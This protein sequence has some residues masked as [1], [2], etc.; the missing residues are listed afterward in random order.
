MATSSRSKRSILGTS[1]R[2]HLELDSTV[3]D[4]EYCRLE[5][6]RFEPDTNSFQFNDGKWIADHNNFPIDNDNILDIMII[7]TGNPGTSPVLTVKIDSKPPK[8][9][10]ANGPFSSNGR[11]FFSPHIPV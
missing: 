4:I 11:A 2:I 5:N 7:V 9:Y 6:I 8:T 10:P 1:H 3:R